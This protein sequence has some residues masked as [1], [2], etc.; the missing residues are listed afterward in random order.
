MHN[1]PE[2]DTGQTVSPGPPSSRPKGWRRNISLAGP[3]EAAHP[4]GAAIMTAQD[5]VG[6]PIDEAQ[7]AQV[8][9]HVRSMLFRLRALIRSRT[10]QG[11]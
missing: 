1:H 3:V 4:R 7:A 9:T 10:K 8:R 6:I 2:L 11:A 5:K